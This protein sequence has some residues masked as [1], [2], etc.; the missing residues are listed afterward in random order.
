MKELYGMFVKMEKEED[1]KR[2]MT[3]ETQYIEVKN[4]EIKLP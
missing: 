2:D 4:K 3:V 1:E